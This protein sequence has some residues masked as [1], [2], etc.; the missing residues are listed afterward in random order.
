MSHKL[1]VGCVCAE[2]LSQDYINP[3]RREIELRRTA[4]QTKPKPALAAP[5]TWVSRCLGSLPAGWSIVKRWRIRDR[6][7]S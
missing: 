7:V 6:P 5:Q 2:N 4:K 3:R 1:A